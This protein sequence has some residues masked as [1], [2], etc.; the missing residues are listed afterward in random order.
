MASS[1]FGNAAF[2]GLRS[3]PRVAPAVRR[4]D[5]SAEPP[6]VTPQLADAPAAQAARASPAPPPSSFVKMLG[7]L[8][9]AL[10]MFMALFDVQIV[11]SSIGE[12]QAGISASNDEI[13]WIQT[14]YLIA[15]VVVI[16]LS[17]WL[18]G[19][20][21][22][23]WTFAASV[24]GFTISSVLCALAWNISSMIVFRALQGF[25]GGAMIPLAFATG[26][27]LF[28]GPR[29]SVIPAILGLTATMAPTLG[30]SVGGWITQTFSWHWLFFLNIL[31]GIVISIGVPLLI[32]VDKPDLRL[33]KGVDLLS[34]PFIALSLGSLEYV[35]EEG[36]RNDWFES[37]SITF[38]TWAAGV[39]FIIVIC[40][41]LTHKQPVLDL[42]AFASRN[43]SLGCL[44]SFIFGIGMFGSIYVIPVFLARV[45]GFDSLQI[46]E[47]VFITGVFQ[48]LSVPPAAILARKLDPRKTLALGFALYGAGI[49]LVT[50][51]TALWGGNELFWP[52]AIRGFG[53][54]F[55]IVPITALTL[56]ELPPERLKAA[57]GLYN[58]MRNLG[59][60]VGIAVIGILLQNRERLHYARLAE[61]VRLGNPGVLG[62]LQGLAG[63]LATTIGDPARAELA[64]V[65]KLGQLVQREAAVLTFVD[66]LLF[67]AVLFFASI[68]LVP[69]LR[70]LKAEAGGPN[71]H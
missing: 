11:A 32:K 48:I 16:P 65:H 63:R 2:P 56:G 62:S 8:L 58:L 17:G 69:L 18:A 15:E 13:S 20:F 53:S 21:S 23:R 66:T 70:R 68:P 44:F 5:R 27:A 31:P 26:F 9:M 43:F 67:M 46:G 47:A 6:K 59:G 24:I 28:E 3:R 57:S 52:Q 34:I 29:A 41:S 42:R 54:M 35:L 14:A 71:A 40:R 55:V 61:H 10:G 37:S 33:L 22:T 60:A 25:T 51:M 36:V 64:A 49:W 50:P 1:L 39:S 7:F 19:I 45:R 4:D 12:I 38:F 30:P